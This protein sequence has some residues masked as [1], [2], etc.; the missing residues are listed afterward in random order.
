MA[1]QTDQRLDR[2]DERLRVT[3][4][5]VADMG[6]HTGAPLGCRPVTNVD[7]TAV[8]GLCCCLRKQ[9]TW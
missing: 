8:K 6:E 2:L 9:D 1:Q 4:P 5:G 3:A 7:A